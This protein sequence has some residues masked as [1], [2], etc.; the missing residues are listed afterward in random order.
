LA[1]PRSVADV[2][3]GH[4]NRVFSLKFLHDVPNVLLSGGWDNTV[5]VRAADFSHPHGHS[6]TCVHAHA[7]TKACRQAHTAYS[8]DQRDAHALTHDAYHAKV[9]LALCTSRRR[10]IT[11]GGVR[12]RTG[13]GHPRGARCEVNL[14]PARVRRLGRLLPRRRPDGVL[15]WEGADG[16]VLPRDV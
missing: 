3:P 7:H 11:G 14:R 6:R 16:G 15:A 13:V 4:S 8:R 5:Q 12:A 9:C 10:P 2:T 1:A